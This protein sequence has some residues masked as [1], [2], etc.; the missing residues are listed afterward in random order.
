MLF[1]KMIM[2]IVTKLSPTLP[3]KRIVETK[4][5]ELREQDSPHISNVSWYYPLYGIIA[6]LLVRE[7]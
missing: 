1:N 3:R 5:L 4:L 6:G 7:V 2:M